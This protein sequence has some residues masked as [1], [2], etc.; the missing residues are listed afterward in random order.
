[1]KRPHRAYIIAALSILFGVLIAQ[2]SHAVNCEEFWADPTLPIDNN[3]ACAIWPTPT[4]NADGS[5]LTDLAGFRIYYGPDSSALLQTDAEARR[6]VV[7]WIEIDNEQSNT[8]EIVLN[9]TEPTT[10][11]FGITAYDTAGNE[12]VISELVS[13]AIGFVNTEAPEQVKSFRIEM[14]I[15]V[16]VDG[17]EL[18]HP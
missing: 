2:N 11:F 5:P 9:I 17:G 10:I 8:F 4:Q 12:G 18:H 14:R 16:P 3:V 6:A 13:K 1:M 7:S 15:R